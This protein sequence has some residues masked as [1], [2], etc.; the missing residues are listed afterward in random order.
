MSSDSESDA[1]ELAQNSADEEKSENEIDEELPTAETTN[2]VEKEVT[3][4]D[5][6]IFTIISSPK[7]KK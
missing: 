7:K 3:W 4:S 6:V 5:L 1:N 2:A